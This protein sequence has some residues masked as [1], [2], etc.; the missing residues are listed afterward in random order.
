[1]EVCGERHEGMWSG[2][3]YDGKCRGMIRIAEYMKMRNI[4]EGKEERE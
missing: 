1:M 4:G 2:P 3:S